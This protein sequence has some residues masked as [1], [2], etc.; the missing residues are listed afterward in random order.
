M[1]PKLVI[2]TDFLSKN[3]YAMD[4]LDFGI[5]NVEMSR[6]IHIY[7]SNQTEVTAKWSLNYIKFPKK[8]TIG[9]NTTTPWEIENMEKTDDAEVF[10]FNIANGLLK[11]KSLPLR[12]VPEGLIVP[13]V[14]K[15][16]E[17][18][19]FLPQKILIKFKPKKNVLYK[20]KF[21]FTADTGIHCD[22]I[23][24]GRGSYEENHD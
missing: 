21:R 14:P 9:H 13:P 6:T 20:S 17:E 22:V 24:K 8:S 23:L 5:V 3:D 15:D 7:L 1:R 2:L 10:E 12:K 18:K 4:E 11:G 16:E 19:K